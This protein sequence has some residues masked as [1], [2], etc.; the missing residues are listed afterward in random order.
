MEQEEKIFF[1]KIRN[2]QCLVVNCG[3]CSSDQKV[4]GACFERSSFNKKK[5]KQYVLERWETIVWE[6]RLDSY[7]SRTFLLAEERGSSCEN[8]CDHMADSHFAL[9]KA[10]L[11]NRTS[12]FEGYRITVTIRHMA[13]VLLCHLIWVFWIKTFDL[14]CGLYTIMAFI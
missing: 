13:I 7:S 5:W 10:N 6:K 8:V 14:Q 9:P 12:K 1:K 3:A 11:Q 4:Q 2:S